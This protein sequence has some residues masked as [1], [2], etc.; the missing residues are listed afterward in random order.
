MEAKSGCF[1]NVQRFE[2][3]NFHIQYSRVERERRINRVTNNRIGEAGVMALSLVVVN[4]IK[5]ACLRESTVYRITVKFTGRK[6][7]QFIRASH[8]STVKVRFLIYNR[9]VPSV[10]LR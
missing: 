5:R 3:N 1:V 7:S 8:F 10:L 2:S 6:R 4:T 9:I